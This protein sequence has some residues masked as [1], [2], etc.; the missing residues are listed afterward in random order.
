MRVESGS[1]FVISM[2]ERELLDADWILVSRLGSDDYLDYDVVEALL[3]TV[4][5]EQKNGCDT[6][7]IKQKEFENEKMRDVEPF[8]F[9]DSEKKW[10]KVG[11]KSDKK[12]EK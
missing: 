7:E 12:W 5:D 10:E 6:V 11:K 3:S 4:S 2:R 1:D 9:L 8:N